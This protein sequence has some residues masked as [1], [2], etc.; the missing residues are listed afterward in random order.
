MADRNDLPL[1]E[2]DSTRFVPWIIGV[3]AYLA[4]LA[5][6]AALMLSNIA[7]E[8]SA[9]LEGTL[10]V[11]VPISDDAT[12]DQKDQRVLSAVRVLLATPGVD[13]ARPIPL[14][15]VAEMLEPWLGAAAKSN[16]LPLPL[17]TFGWKTVRRSTSTSLC[18]AE[19]AAQRASTRIT[20]AWQK[21]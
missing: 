16:D 5:L 9:G 21:R 3:M 8:W 18:G 13:S 1:S 7:A 6:A 20:W 2:D 4:A 17:S 11:Q 12:A 15:E 19:R 10:T 14:A